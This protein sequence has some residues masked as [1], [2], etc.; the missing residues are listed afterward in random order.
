[1]QRSWVFDGIV[2][3][4]DSFPTF[5]VPMTQCYHH[6]CCISQETR[7]FS[8]TQAG[9]QWHDHSSLQHQP[10]GLKPSSNLTAT[11]VAGTMGTHPIPG[12]ECLFF[13]C[14]WASD[15]RIFGLW[16][17]GLAP[18]APL[19][20]SGPG[21]HA[22]DCTVSFPN[23]EAFRLGLSH[24]ARFSHSPACRQPTMGLCLCNHGGVRGGL[25]ESQD[26]HYQPAVIKPC[27]PSVN[28]DHLGSQSSYHC[29]EVTRNSPHNLHHHFGCQERLSGKSGLLPP[30]ASNKQVLFLPLLK[31][32]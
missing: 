4:L 23:F 2:E 21:P 29:Q 16:T 14:P 13:S 31:W 12:V 7:S 26:F 1:M 20:F 24:A 10:P 9:V 8:A 25:V 32:H 11:W 19:G 27:H 3:L 28:G 5:H 18:V 17:L 30:F 22:A 15:S 6:P